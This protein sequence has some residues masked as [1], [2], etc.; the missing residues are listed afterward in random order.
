MATAGVPEE[1]AT[2][3]SPWIFGAVPDV[4]VSLTWVP[5]F[6]VWH[7]LAGGPSAGAARAAAQG[8]TLALLVSFL[9]Q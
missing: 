2:R 5:V 8:V 3:R 7:V 6:L 4:V 9:H 1:S